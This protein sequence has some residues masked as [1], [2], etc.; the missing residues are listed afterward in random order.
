[1]KF[2]I[3]GA[4]VLFAVTG[5]NDTMGTGESE[6]PT[7]IETASVDRDN[8]AVNVRDRA[9]DVKTPLDQNDNQKDIDTTAN[10]RTRVV[11]MSTNA[12]TT[13]FRC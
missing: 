2:K 10:I 6:R 11:E 4:L 1:M 7:G 8:S 3:A 9:A 13:I 5:C 12:Q